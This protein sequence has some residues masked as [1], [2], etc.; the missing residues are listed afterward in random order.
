MRVSHKAL[1]ILAIIPAFFFALSAS[2]LL[3]TSG[4]YLY[5]G[6]GY[7]QRSV[8]LHGQPT[9]DPNYGFTS[10][11]LGVRAAEDIFSGQLPLWNPYE[12]FGTPLLG[13]M[14]S[15]ALFP[16]TWLQALPKGQSLEQALLQVVAGIGTLLFL[17]KLGL[18]W[19]AALAAGLL[20]ELNGVFAWLRNA[21][22][23]PVAFLP[24][25]FLIVESLYD[26]NTRKL[27][28][29]R[30]LH[31][32][33]LGGLISSL[34]VYSGFPEEVYLYS[35]LVLIWTIFRFFGLSGRS[36][37]DF[38]A[39][40][41]LFAFVGGILSL[42]VLLAFA[43]YLPQAVLGG[44]SENGFYG[45]FLSPAVLL[46]YLLPY[47]YGPIFKAGSPDI[48]GIWGSTGGYLGL[49]PL[50]CGATVL[51]LPERRAVKF[52]L[53][54]WIVI[55]VGVSHGL[56]GIYQAFMLLPLTK[57]AAC[58][59]YLDASWIFAFVVLIGLLLDELERTAW[60]TT[61]RALLIAAAGVFIAIAI[62]AIAAESV[63]LPG[64]RQ[65]D[66]VRTG[67]SVSALVA[68]AV[69]AWVVHLACRKESSGV[70]AAL[71]FL[72][73]AEALLNFAVPY[74]SYPHKEKV[75]FALA[76]FL[77]QNAGLQRVVSTESGQIGANY[78]SYFG[79]SLLNWNDLP[80]P[81]LAVDYVRD[82]LDPYVREPILYLP[83][84]IG[85]SDSERMERQAL[86][87]RRLSDYA[88][89]GVKYILS[90]DN[91]ASVSPYAVGA[92][93]K[94]PL[95]LDAGQKIELSLPAPFKN[96]GSVVSLS[97]LIGTYQGKSNGR[98]IAELCN[99]EI[100][101][102]GSAAL[103][104]AFDNKPV[105]FNLDQ[106]LAIMPDAGLR[107]ALR[108]EGGDHGVAI[109]M[110]AMADQ[111]IDFGASSDAP[112]LRPRSAPFLAF[113]EAGGSAARRVYGGKTM[114][115][116]EL[117]NVRPYFD[118]AECKLTPMTRNKVKAD[119]PQPARMTRLEL[120]M[121]GWEAFV[122]DTK[123]NIRIVDQA[124][125]EVDLP[126]GSSVVKF[127]YDP[128]AVRPAL[129]VSAGALLFVF[130]VLS[131]RLFE[132]RPHPIASIT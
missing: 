63:L 41:G 45:A 60:R 1:I 59:R 9:I 53:L 20:F 114:N 50:L 21:I 6:L 78:G 32:I 15:A 93:D 62:A 110:G 106:P 109:W 14:Q 66:A 3:K 10:E 13:E 126:E 96:G 69:L 101:V 33:A 118:S 130:I 30:R 49:A 86:F 5:S 25:L 83:D 68:A 61:Q 57:I 87:V 23:N 108:K 82:R 19:R 115:V 99:G 48:S 54:I 89:S 111:Q 28:F 22:Y 116:Y 7:Q 113:V 92:D 131:G 16:F 37:L 121:S 55:A 84:P 105:E 47:V 40:I 70:P 26:C 128:T 65:F 52:L 79:F 43:N 36:R 8:P 80:V 76:D 64:L 2:N 74:L 103:E 124:F 117:Q 35:I 71:A 58:F 27:S 98:L 123:T 75:D 4:V 100:C 56:P 104:D 12:G 29:S 11:A 18:S 42:P 72:V 94:Y 122:N 129:W 85:L 112:A 39:D 102:H 38:A 119:C 127:S 95:N 120:A 77:R 81:R 46:Q 24:W 107:L 91:P 44:H 125:Q 67:A 88:Q 31:W 90:G 132:Y 51:Q 97:V 17:R 73:V 34:A